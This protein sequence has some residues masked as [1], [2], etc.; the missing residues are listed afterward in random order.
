[1]VEKYLAKW[2]KFPQHILEDASAGQYP[3][4]GNNRANF[5]AFYRRR[6]HFLSMV[7]FKLLHNWLIFHWPK[8]TSS[9][10]ASCSIMD[11]I[12]EFNFSEIRPTLEQK[13]WMAGLIMSM[14]ETSSSL[15]VC[16]AWFSSIDCANIIRQLGKNEDEHYSHKSESSQS[17]GIFCIVGNA[18]N[19]YQRCS[20]SA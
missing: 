12:H 9:A 16:Q 10:A 14:V 5:F 18:H 15:V 20:A 2:V 6:R 13:T 17:L 7:S 11:V 3:S 1:M 4:Q 8:V 19:F